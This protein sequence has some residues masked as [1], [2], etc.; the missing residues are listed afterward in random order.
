MFKIIKNVKKKI[1]IKD[2]ILIIVVKIQDYIVQ[3]I[4]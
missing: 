2:H 1:V 4:S 3:N